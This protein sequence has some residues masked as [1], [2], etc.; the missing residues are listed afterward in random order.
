MP[1]KNYEDHLDAQRRWYSRN[2]DGVRASK[3]RQKA[4][5]A[6]GRAKPT[7]CDVCGEASWRI[8]FD[9]CHATTRFRG[10]LCYGCN[11]ALGQVK[12]NPETLRALASYLEGNMKNNHTESN[13]G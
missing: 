8:V 11:V 7:A 1:Y 6:G 5:K 3:I 9:H 2:K 13:N 4:K 12:D 10:W